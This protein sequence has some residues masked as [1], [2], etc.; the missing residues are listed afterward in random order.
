[1][2]GKPFIS[3]G[4][5]IGSK[6]SIVRDYLLLE[7]G[8]EFRLEDESGFLLLERQTKGNVSD[9]NMRRDGTIE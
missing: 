3:I 6:T 9:W 8:E 7:N 2:T 5:A 1:M 4:E